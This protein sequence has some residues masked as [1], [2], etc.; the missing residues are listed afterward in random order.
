M[1]YSLSPAILPATTE[2][3][4][5]NQTVS[6]LKGALD[7]V[8]TSIVVVKGVNTAGN[9]AV[10]TASSSFTITGQYYDNWTYGIVYEEFVQDG[11]TWANTLVTVSNWSNI[12]ANINFVQS[13]TAATSPSSKTA[14]YAVTINGVTTLPLTQVINNNY[15]PGALTLVEYVAKGKV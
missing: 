3:T 6:V 15:T 2:K 1:A 12:S 13:Y 10:A 8:I 9:I 11:T 4:Q 5:L 7:P 14:S